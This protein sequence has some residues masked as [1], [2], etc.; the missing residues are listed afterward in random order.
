MWA[1]AA[2]TDRLLDQRDAGTLDQPV[3]GPSPASIHA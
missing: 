1:A 3:P 2:L